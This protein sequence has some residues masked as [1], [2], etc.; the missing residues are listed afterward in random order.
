L[1]DE[2]RPSFG[3]PDLELNRLPSPPLSPSLMAS[4]GVSPCDAAGIGPSQMAADL[5][6]LA[7]I[8]TPN[9]VYSGSSQSQLNAGPT[10]SSVHRKPPS[11]PPPRLPS[12]SGGNGVAD[13]GKRPHSS[14]QGHGVP[15]TGA[16]TVSQ[17]GQAPGP[18][19]SPETGGS[20]T[21]SF[22]RPKMADRGEAVAPAGPAPAQDKAQ[23][24]NLSR[25]SSSQAPSSLMA[26]LPVL[27]THNLKLSSSYREVLGA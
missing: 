26:D 2:R 22:S 7:S 27:A 4:T 10:I 19:E 25:T 18:W 24:M 16:S 15:M 12:G 5:A 3:L 14:H 23:L 1:V 13:F 21:V 6:F 9:H 11:G 8:P 20:G 17:Q